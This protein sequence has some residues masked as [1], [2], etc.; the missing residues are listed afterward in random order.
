M[1]N[2]IPKVS[3]ILKK[4][5]M[6]LAVLIIFMA[7]FSSIFRSLTPFAKKYKTEIEHHLTALIGLPVSIQSMETGWYW[8]QP[9]LKLNQV[10]VGP[11]AQQNF[12]IN[13]LLVGINLFKSLWHWQLQPGAL[14]IDD[15]HLNFR[16]RASHWS[17]DG[18]ST[19]SINRGEG[20]SEQ[21]KRILGWLSQQERLVIKRVSA[22]FYFSDGGLIPVNVLNVS[23]AINGGHYKFNGEALLEQTSSTH[24]QLLGHGYFDPAH[25]EDIDGQ[26]YFSAKNIVLAQWQSVLPRVTQQLEGGKGNI[27][28]WADVS[29]GTLTSVQAQIRLK[30]LAWRLLNTQK[31]QL[32]QSFFANLSWKP[33]SMGWQLQAD[34][35]LLR[36]G[37]VSWPTNQ[38]LVQY[39][40]AQ[41]SYKIFVKSI[42]IES[43]LSNA[44]NWP[45]SIRI[46]LDMKPKGILRDTQ[47]SITMN[48]N[49]SSI[50]A[51]PPPFAP[52][53]VQTKAAADKT[54]LT[55]SEGSINYILSRF[56][57]LEWQGRGSVPAV[58][59]LSGVINWQPEE[60]HLELDSTNTQIKFKGYPL[61]KLSLLGGA[62]DWKQLNDGFRVSIDRFILNQ[63]E[64]TLSVQGVVDQVTEDSV[65][66]VRFGAEFSG[67]NWQQ[68]I[69][70]LPKES[71]KPK[72]Y[73]WLQKD[74]KC[75]KE[76]TGKITLNG[77]VKEFPFDNNTGEFTIE[78][79]A[80]GGELAINSKWQVIKEIEGYIHVKNRNLSIDLIHAD[81]QG[82]PSQ[83]INLRIDDIGSNK[84]NLL[85]QGSMQG[86]L[87]KMLRYVLASPLNKKL[88]LLRMVS[89]QGGALLNLKV[90]VPL[91]PGD[92]KILAQ[93]DVR[94]KNNRVTVKHELG[95]FVLEDFL[96]LLKFDETGVI[97]SS[98]TANAW[99]YPLNIKIQSIKQ[100][101]PATTIALDGKFTIDSLKKQFNSSVFSFI[102]G[103]F[104]AT[105]VLKLVNDVAETDS[106]SLKSSLEGVVIKLPPP[107]GKKY[108][109]KA[110]LELNLDLIPQKSIRISGNYDRRLSADLLFQNSKTGFGFTSGQINLGHAKA[111]NQNKPGLSVTGTLKG[112]DLGEWKQFWSE[113]NTAKTD[114]S[115]LDKLRYIQVTVDKLSFFKQQFDAMIVKAK[116]LANQDW[117]VH[118]KQKNVSAELTYH[119][120]TN[121]LSGHA[122]YLHLTKID[123]STDDA[124][125]AKELS[126][127][128][129]PNLNLRIDNLIVG[130]LEVGDL[131]LKSA[132]TEDQ[133]L[134]KYCR[135][136]SPVYQFDIQG[137][138]IQKPSKNSTHLNVKLT[139]NNLGKTLERWGI[140][141][142]VDAKK[143]YM[144]FQGGWNQSIYKFAL[145]S[146]NG[147]VSL[148]LKNGIITHLSRETEEKLELGK[149]LS[150]LSLQ[151]IPR[152]LQLDFSDLAHEGYSFDIFQGNFNLNK[153]IMHTEDSYLD[154][155]VAYASMKG[156]LDL[157]RRIYDLNLS[158]SPHITAS[159]P[160]VA[161]IAGGP[162]AGVAVW[163]ASKIINQSMQKISSYSY[164]I[165]GPWNDPIVQQLS[166]EK[167]VIK[168]Q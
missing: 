88:S 35:I 1:S 103:S 146:L 164:K 16:E 136:D 148:Q 108:E 32:I 21:S 66:Q 8:F 40:K 71:M 127:K 143:G 6:I 131:T 25:Y 62:L 26:F 90:Q 39:N 145:A 4:I 118:L 81:F 95:H 115:L 60:G 100:P 10:T 124:I 46:L 75:I 165:S 122:E 49:A 89:L 137:A 53:L 106:I 70:Y 72:L 50:P 57:Q 44:I 20:I 28:L 138:W 5:W 107:L 17:I 149:L 116:K 34:P 129:I 144:E 101:E 11:K 147:T 135:I 65:G 77:L 27:A 69:P 64:L 87:Q 128:Q 96:G 42:I 123:T 99:G 54:L 38:L 159:L 36:V 104:F 141:P 12:H 19:Q 52:P 14:Y 119:A 18:I 67:K 132:S 37:E 154:G 113:F 152:R 74:L 160:I 80:S 59:H 130:L 84:E 63:P 120:P 105:A 134:I 61:Q 158:I 167:K 31:S 3:K 97:D 126:P 139:I 150:I 83:Q 163:V 68:W 161:T 117:S 112:F 9:V 109:V 48:T 41:Q 94:F 7:I 73:E 45:R 155:P 121:E 33:D 51:I 92:D 114:F 111:I 110:P 58:S 47:V 151:T 76:A 43:L 78:S 82:V 23:V 29:H 56:E 162:I 55:T 166:I 140:L 30:R 24:F 125:D 91:H 85:V 102:D 15:M 153:G 86:S 157:V 22:Y 98:L 79:H 2:P 133:W 156:D 93:G 142:A 13:K 168:K